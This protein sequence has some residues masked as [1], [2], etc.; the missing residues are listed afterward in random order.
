MAALASVYSRMEILPGGEIVAR[1]LEDLGR[2]IESAEALLVSMA[3]TRLRGLGIAVPDRVLAAP[4]ARFY[5]LLASR[6]GAGAHS[7]YNA[8]R[9]RLSS[10]LR[11]ARC[12]E[13]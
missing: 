4:E 1:G 10:F 7:K 12:A 9:R 8:W 2:G 11:A 13:K 5:R 6:H 3:V